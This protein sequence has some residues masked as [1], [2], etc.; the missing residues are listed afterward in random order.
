MRALIRCITEDV[1]LPVIAECACRSLVGSSGHKPAVEGPESK[2]IER[3]AIAAP[4]DG[5]EFEAVRLRI[6]ILGIGD[7]VA[8]AGVRD[9]SEEDVELA[10]PAVFITMFG[11]RPEIHTTN[12]P[13]YG[14]I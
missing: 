8:V 7:E 14:V 12:S 1:S 9:I 3:A 2:G 13:G 4:Q 11:V 5:R 10:V 6:C